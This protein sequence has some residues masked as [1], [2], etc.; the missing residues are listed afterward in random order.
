MPFENEIVVAELSGKQIKK[1]LKYLEK[2]KRAHPVS[3]IKILAGKNYKIVNATI[4][5]NE[6]KN[7]QTY[8]VATS[9]YLFHGGD[10]MAF[11]R[12]PVNLYHSDYKIRN[13]LIDYFTRIDTTRARVDNRYI[14]E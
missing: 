5:G 13:A 14:R 11:F 2:A 4:A 8:F 1:M 10:N 9:D 12:D 6:I 3:G 7:D